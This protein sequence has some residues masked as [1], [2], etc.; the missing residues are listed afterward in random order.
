MDCSIRA[1]AM[2]TGMTWDDAYDELAI[3]GREL[4]LMM[5]SVESIED[6]LDYNFERMCHYSKTLEEFCEEFPIGRYIV[7]MNGHLTT[8]INGD[9]I[10]SFDPS[11]RIIRCSWYVGK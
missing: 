9:V 5:D 7:S 4:G 11:E 1:L 3:N 2:A 6:Y 8:V 10:D